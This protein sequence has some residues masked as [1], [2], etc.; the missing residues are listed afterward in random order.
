MVM[1]RGV[2]DFLAAETDAEIFHSDLLNYA[3]ELRR[4]GDP[5]AHFVYLRVAEEGDG[6]VQEQALGYAGALEGRGD[7][8]LRLEMLAGSFLEEA[9]HPATVAGM[10]TGQLVYATTRFAA[11]SRLWNPVS[12]QFTLGAWGARGTAAGLGLMAE[13]PT[14]WGVSKGLQE[15]LHPGTQSWDAA[16]NY[17]ELASLGLTLGVLRGT[18]FASGSVLRW[19][20]PSVVLQR[21]LPPT[22]TIGGLFLAHTV[23]EK[24]G[25]RDPQDNASRLFDSVIT[26][27]QFGIAGRLSHGILGRR[28]Q[29]WNHLMEHQLQE[30]QRLSSFPNIELQSPLGLQMAMAS[31]AEGP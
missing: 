23:E 20:Q 7:W 13:V 10:A 25:L 29:Q 16:T 21:T 9:T 3:H 22:A 19:A 8:G 31:G 14:F 17:R 30:R 26:Y 24:V 1:P 6:A 28:F 2:P 27:F 5:A 18:G 12:R 4:Q 11:L 15:Y